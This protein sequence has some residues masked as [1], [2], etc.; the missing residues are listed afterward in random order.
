MN[1][2]AGVSLTVSIVL[3]GACGWALM[4]MKGLDEKLEKLETPAPDP[5][6]LPEASKPGESDP[7]GVLASRIDAL[8]R[9]LD[10]ADA[11]FNLS[12]AAFRKLAGES[13]AQIEAQTIEVMAKLTE[14]RAN[15]SEKL[16]DEILEAKV[17]AGLAEKR[18]KDMKKF[19]KNTGKKRFENLQD[20][21][22]LTDAQIK[23]LTEFFDGIYQEWSDTLGKI[24]SGEEVDPKEIEKKGEETKVKVDAK[25]KETLTP[26]QYTTYKKDIEADFFKDPFQQR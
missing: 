11:E 16:T 8:E 4:E 20:K 23:E 1:K 21:L 22:K 3:C 12:A 14:I 13:E 6:A 25:M 15:P 10:A 18:K 9:R 26:E 19:L 17:R 24:F 2:L 7:R 5:R